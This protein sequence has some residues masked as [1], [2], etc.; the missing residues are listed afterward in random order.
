[1]KT[2]IISRLPAA[3][4]LAVGLSFTATAVGAHNSSHQSAQQDPN[5]VETSM[6]WTGRTL[7]KTGQTL[8]NTGRTV[9]HTPQ[10][11]GE[12]FTGERKLISKDGLFVR[13]YRVSRMMDNDDLEPNSRTIPKGRGDRLRL[14]GSEE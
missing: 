6:G 11:V 9:L 1:M 14:F 13:E 2:N 4:A 10:I 3:L 12:T 5:L 7:S 8:S